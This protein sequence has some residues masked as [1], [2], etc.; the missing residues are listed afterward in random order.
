MGDLPTSVQKEIDEIASERNNVVISLVYVR[1]KRKV[2]HGYD[3]SVH[4]NKTDPQLLISSCKCDYCKNLRLYVDNKIRHH[5][6]RK[7]IDKYDS[8]GYYI[9]NEKELNR[10]LSRLRD[11]ELKIKKYKQ[12][13]DRVKR[14]LEI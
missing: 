2:Q 8:Y 1:H 10:D 5:R 14:E 3:P 12:I 4:K 9:N 6:L 7:S 11:L 13:K